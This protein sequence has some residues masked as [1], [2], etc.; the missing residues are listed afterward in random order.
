MLSAIGHWISEK[1]D[2]VQSGENNGEN[3]Q[4]E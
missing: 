1:L 3:L 2:Q 4:R